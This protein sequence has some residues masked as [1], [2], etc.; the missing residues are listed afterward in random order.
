MVIPAIDPQSASHHG[1]VVGQLVTPPAAIPM[2]QIVPPGTVPMGQPAPPSAVSLP[3]I[4]PTGGSRRS[5]V[6][7]SIWVAGLACGVTG[8]LFARRTYARSSLREKLLDD[9]LPSLSDTFSA[10]IREY[11]KLG[12]EQIRTYFHERA[13]QVPEFVKHICSPIFLDRLGRC[14]GS[15]EE[16]ERCL[17]GAYC[18][19]VAS[20]AGI[21]ANVEAIATHIGNLLDTTWMEYCTKLSQRWNIQLK[22]YGD[23]LE[24]ANFTQ[25]VS[26]IIR[27]DLRRAVQQVNSTGSIPSLGEAL[28]GIG[29]SAIM[30]LP[31]IRM[32]TYG[33]IAGIPVFLFLA[34]K[35][36]W[37]LVIPVLEQRRDDSIAQV[38]SA[39]TQMSGRIEGEFEREIRRRIS[40]LHTWQEN[41]IREITNRIVVQRV[42]LI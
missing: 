23:P 3:H 24:P 6:R 8:F 2:G 42:G 26:D 41:A 27:E 4:T 38:T 37:N 22:K 10:H 11:P 12:T 28:G 30:V 36:V 9:A 21:Q 13:L 17:M 1:P 31:M 14:S 39:M 32:G 20:E 40:D 7:R 19:R 29:K 33:I 5:F 35:H 25:R 18:E 34:A 15:S 16:K